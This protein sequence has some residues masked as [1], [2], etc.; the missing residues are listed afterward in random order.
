VGE[1]GLVTGAAGFIG[2]KVCLALQR[3]GWRIRAVDAFRDP[4]R[5]RLSAERLAQRGVAVEIGDLSVDDLRR[6]LHGVDLVVHLAGRPG[7]RDTDGAAHYRDNVVSLTRMLRALGPAAETHVVFSSSSSVL[8]ARPSA[9]PRAPDVHAAWQG[10][11]LTYAESKLEAERLLQASS[12]PATILRFFS[13]YGPGQRPGMAFA[14]ACEALV[15]D[16]PLKI[17]GDGSQARDWTYV[18]DVVRAVLA[19]PHAA[20]GSYDVGASEP[21]SLAAALRVLEHVSGRRLR[22]EFHS[23]H[24]LDAASTLADA[25][26]RIPGWAPQVSLRQGL[27]WQ[28]HH[29]SSGHAAVA[30]LAGTDELAADYA[31]AAARRAGYR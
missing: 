16:R 5:N 6:W 4:A 20:P 24:P 28:W 14:A 2:E 1:W 19:S 3:A 8:T 13:V 27:A 30:G 31:N 9:S 18:D 26:R 22:R 10:P 17:F 21:S 25:S 15:T 23:A 12:V 11:R 7:V 29:H